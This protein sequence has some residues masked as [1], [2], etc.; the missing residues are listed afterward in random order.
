MSDGQEVVP[1]GDI[2]RLVIISHGMWG[3]LSD[4]DRMRAR[5]QDQGGS[6]TFV[7]A[8]TSNVFLK[9]YS[10]VD[11]CGTRLA[12][13]IRGLFLP[14][15]LLE[16]NKN[17]SSLSLIGYSAGGLFVRYAIGLLH[18]MGFFSEKGLT[19]DK[20]ITVATPHLGV[21][22]SPK[23][24]LGRTTNRL[25]GM[26]GNIYGGRS[27]EH[28]TLMDRDGTALDGTRLPLLLAMTLPGM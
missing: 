13:E 23:T 28:M 24:W 27:I 5:L 4:M 11:T 8:A 14:S 26:L 21:L 20:V 15:G 9:S 3:R 17:I 19:L 18:Q 1:G 7:Y 6:S 10:G 16:N 2:I 22:S 25:K 12:A